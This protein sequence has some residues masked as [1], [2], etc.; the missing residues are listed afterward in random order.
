MRGKS[1]KAFF[2][3]RM[4]TTIPYGFPGEIW[5]I[6]TMWTLPENPAR[7]KSWCCWSL[8]L[9]DFLFLARRPTHRSPSQ[10]SHKF[11]EFSVTGI[12]NFAAWFQHGFRLK[13]WWSGPAQLLEL[14]QF[15]ELTPSRYLCP[16]VLLE[17]LNFVPGK[18]AYYVVTSHLLGAFFSSS[19]NKSS[20]W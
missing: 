18:Y 9:N 15:P 19:D 5:F 4:S 14:E 17:W 12:T 2:L 6:N 16:K 8:S 13:C 20:T 3:A 11:W 7:E 10:P 1:I